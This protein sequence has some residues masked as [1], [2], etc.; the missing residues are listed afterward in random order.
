M[1]DYS[2]LI[3]DIKE[4]VKIFFWLS[5]KNGEQLPPYLIFIGH[6]RD[7][8]G[9]LFNSGVYVYETYGGEKAELFLVQLPTHLIL[10]EIEEPGC[11]TIGCTTII[12]TWM[13]ETPPGNPEEIYQE[14]MKNHEN[15][16]QPNVLVAITHTND[17]VHTLF[18]IIKRDG[19]KIS[20]GE[21]TEWEEGLPANSSLSKV[22]S[23]FKMLKETRAAMYADN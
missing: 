21:R 4:D 2:V 15:L 17:G 16:P 11:T 3:E 19:D 1:Q 13:G 23:N 7:S 5:T 20:L 12:A 6:A 10:M 8:E 18:Y 22:F 9:M 14:I